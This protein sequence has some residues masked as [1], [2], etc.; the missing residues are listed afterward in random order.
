MNRRGMISIYI[1]AAIVL[2][3][4][5]FLWGIARNWSCRHTRT[6]ER[7][8]RR[9]ERKNKVTTYG[10]YE[11]LKVVSGNCIDCSAGRRIKEDDISLQSRTVRVYLSMIGVPSELHLSNESRKHL[12]KIAGSSVTVRC[13]KESRRPDVLIGEV[14]GT[15][16]EPLQVLQLRE[17]LAQCKEGVAPKEYV[18]AMEEACDARR[19]VFKDYPKFDTEPDPITGEIK[20]LTDEQF[21]SFRRYIN[22]SFDYPE[23]D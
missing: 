11:V 4:L 9:E 1:W 12:E 3:A 5:L 2:L 17:G 20:G 19:G 21:Q 13:K 22:Q 15:S 8:E 6:D 16:A 7:H 18:K 14:F 23:E 10:P